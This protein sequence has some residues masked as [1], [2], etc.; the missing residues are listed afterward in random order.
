MSALRLS[1]FLLLLLLFLPSLGGYGQE[2]ALEIPPQEYDLSESGRT[3]LRWKGERSSLNMAIDPVLGKIDTI[4]RYAF[5]DIDSLGRMI[6][7]TILEQVILPPSLKVLEEGA[8]YCSSLRDVRLNNHLERVEYGAFSYCAFTEILLPASLRY[9]ENAFM[10]CSRLDRVEV[11]ENAPFLAIK[12]GALI[13]LATNTLLYYPSGNLYPQPLLPDDIEAIGTYAFCANPYIQRIRLSKGVRTIA[14][15]A[16]AMATSLITLDLPETVT[17]I[18][19]DAWQFSPVDTLILR[20]AFPPLIVGKNEA[21]KRMRQ[22]H[23]YVPSEALALY[24]GDKFW[25]SH[26]ATIESIDVWEEMQ[27]PVSGEDMPFYLVD[28]VLYLTLPEG[29]RQARLLDKEG[30]LV[31]M[32]Q[33]SGSYPL[34]PGIYLLQLGTETYKVVCRSGQ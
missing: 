8:F 3:L 33:S 24:A 2:V 17:E 10:Y 19:T 34:L 26:F 6:P 7:E 28:R 4:G 14:S 15:K 27:Q 16:F 30:A 20:S 9:F 32:F 22:P 12:N 25:S 21:F 18:D 11:S 13:E 23:L 29:I 1:H 5:S 31:R